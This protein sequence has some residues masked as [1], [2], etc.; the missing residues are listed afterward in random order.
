MEHRWGERFPVDLAVRIAARAF[1]VRAGHL[2]NLSL[3][4]AAVELG[5]DVRVLSRIRLALLMRHRFA[6]ATRVINA[7]VA[8]SY[9][10]GIGLEWCEFAP[11]PVVDL[12]RVA[13]RSDTAPDT[14]G[15]IES[16]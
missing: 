14:Q 9:P 4:G 10:G 12:L 1:P 6:H 3:S 13:T 8:R 7:Y 2:V 11:E 5:F 15:E 16:L